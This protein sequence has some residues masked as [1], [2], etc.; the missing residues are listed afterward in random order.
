VLGTLGEMHSPGFMLQE[1]GIFV[2]KEVRA[3]VF[4]FLFLFIL[5]LSKVVPLGPLARYDFIFLTTLGLQFILWRTNIETSDE[6]KVLSLFHLFGLALEI[7]KTHP[8]IGSW[9]YPEPGFFKL[10]SVPLYSGFMYAAVASYLCQAWRIFKLE[11]EHYPPYIISV[12][13]SAAIYLNFFTHHWLGD[14]RWALAVGVLVVFWRT[15]VLFTVT[16]QPR[17][18]PMVLAF[19]LIGFFIW[20]AEH[21]STFFGAW[22]YPNQ[23]QA[24]TWVAWGKLSSWMLLVI[25]S[26]MLVADLKHVK[27]KIKMP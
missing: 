25:I 27:A 26:F 6:I 1:L 16:D 11:L 2:L 3:C 20:M 21:I 14:W 17:R 13:L 12:P 18:M 9:S 23:V 5:G 4:P 15:S 7:F 24:W 8:A 10:A 19:I 22:V